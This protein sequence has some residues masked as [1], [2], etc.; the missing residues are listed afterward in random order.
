MDIHFLPAEE[1]LDNPDASAGTRKPSSPGSHNMTFRLR[2]PF[3]IA[4]ASVPPAVAALLAVALI[5]LMLVAL[6]AAPD[7]ASAAPGPPLTVDVAQDRHAISPGI[8]G[9]NFADATLAGQI[10]LPVDRWGGNATERYN[11]LEGVTNTGSD[12]YFENLA[13]CFG[14]QYNWC[15]NAD[16]AAVRSYRDF[17]TKDRAAGSD[18]LIALPLAGQVSTSPT[19]GHPFHCG[20][21]KTALAGQDDFDPWDDNCGNGMQG[22][23]WLSAPNPLTTTSRT[24]GPADN[25]GWVDDINTRFGGIG[26]YELGNEPSLW[27]HTH[28]DIHPSP[29]TFDELWQRTRDNAIA[30]KA[31]DAG[32]Q[33][34]ALSEW[35]W[36]NYFCSAADTA[37][38]YCSVSSPDRAAHS[39]TPIALWLLQQA[40][41]YQDANGTRLVDYLD[42][43]YYTQGGNTTDVTRSLWDP[44]FT[45]PSWIDDEISL[46]PR[47]KQWIATGY[48][49]TKIALSEYDL[50]LPDG[51]A[52]K[53]TL[54]VLIQADTLGIFAREGVDLATRW[55]PP[56]A[57]EQLANAWR[58]FR[59]YDGQG[60]KFGSTWVRSTSGNQSQLAVYT[61]QR[62]GDGELTAVVVNKTASELTSSLSLAGFTPGSTAEVYRWAGSGIVT[63]PDQ[64]VVAGGFTASYPAR[65]VTMI[66]VP[67]AGG[68]QPPDTTPPDTTPPVIA[69]L[70]SSAGSSTTA[71][72]TVITYT[73][74]DDSG[75]T[76]VCTPVSGSSVAL[77][78]GTNTITVGCHDAAG[79]SAGASISVLR[80]GSSTA[81][82]VKAALSKR[83]LRVSRR[84]SRAVYLDVELTQPTA[85][86]VRLQRRKAGR[87]RTLTTL[88]PNLAQSSYRLKLTGCI[89]RR[90]LAPARYRI[91]VSSEGD[92]HERV[93]WL[94]VVG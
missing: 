37:A 68:S 2:S 57:S 20:Y 33:T 49:G 23:S 63:A 26:Y 38:G 3:S 15:G 17:I 58:I 89:R 85:I 66:V 77:V 47:M 87:L 35:G 5:S 42:L 83:K 81:S 12:W 72:S 86:T 45:D 69:G 65:S 1:L 60:G 34:L 43:H 74:T 62:T 55:G 6:L 92:Q 90:P 91:S 4:S 14:G 76:P 54:D 51:T 31:H 53:A 7:D 56:D 27:N 88:K 29:V 9:M 10:E 13:D 11:Y 84:C 30:V 28:H 64:A 36:P 82:I 24:W 8:Y 41:A 25:A 40:K 16:H 39:G 19:Y 71:S 75:A 70:A 44:T 32:A 22:G 80:R 67:S 21:P 18:T 73:A 59:D 79:N 93:L 94:R 48:P 50:S 78:L 61:A 52:N 46:I